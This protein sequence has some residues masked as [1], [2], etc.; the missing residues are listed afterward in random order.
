MTT[1][2]Y[3]NVVL[4]LLAVA[5][6]CQAAK[7]L[8]TPVA[9]QAPASSQTSAR[10]PADMN[11]A[12]LAEVRALRSDVADAARNSLRAQMLVARVQL[13]EQRLI[14]LDRRR[15]EGVAKVADVSERTRHLTE[16][17][18]SMNTALLRLSDVR[19]NGT[20]VPARELAAQRVDLEMSLRAAQAEL[21]AM[22]IEEQRIRNEQADVDAALATETNRWT[23]FNA[24]LDDLERSLPK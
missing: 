1:H 7:A 13:Q 4:T 3:T 19:P 5:L 14:Y 17:V 18:T 6:V 15:T 16:Q 21:E 24:R 12:L 2:R 10:A 20:T 23:D 22:R 8:S 11:A 9:A